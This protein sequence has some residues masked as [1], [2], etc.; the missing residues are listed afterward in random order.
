MFLGCVAQAA[1]AE[2]RT[3]YSDFGW[4]DDYNMEALYFNVRIV[5]RTNDVIADLSCP[6]KVS[7]GFLEGVVRGYKGGILTQAQYANLT[8]CET[9]EGQC[10]LRVSSNLN[11]EHTLTYKGLRRLSYA[12]VL[13]RL[14][15]LPRQRTVSYFD[16]NHRGQSHPG[17]GG[18]IQLPTKQCSRTTEQVLGL[19]DV[20][21]EL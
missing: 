19:H 10:G 21:S 9:L 1:K 15:Q 5:E 13:H 3:F 20:R 7:N 18:S 14:W 6:L 12:A 2:L 4:F 11:L 8:Q 17:S 16:F